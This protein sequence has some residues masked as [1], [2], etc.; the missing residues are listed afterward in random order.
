M[1]Q[2]VYELHTLLDKAGVRPPFVLVGHSYGGW[3]VRLYPY[4]YA[5]EV[6]GMV[7]IEAGGTNPWRLQPNGRLVRASELA[8]GK[9]IPAVQISNPLKESDVPPA[10]LTQMKLAAQVEGPTA[11]EAP[12][13]KL[14]SDA[15]QMRTWSL[16]R[17]QHFVAGSNPAESDELVDLMTREKGEHPLGDIPLSVMTR[18]ISDETGPDARTL[19]ED[20]QQDQ[21]SMILPS[22]NGKQV[23][24]AHSG[25]HILLDEP[26]FVIQT[27]HDVLFSIRK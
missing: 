22:R 16:S 19:E 12:R 15:Q 8:T 25:H 3:L 14:P 10:A 23:I 1:H 27:V 24:A 2:L 20:H 6:A 5:H 11:N 18:G 17:W 21:A 4:T 26:E 9:P 7:L 13:N